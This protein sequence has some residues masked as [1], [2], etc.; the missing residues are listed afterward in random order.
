MPKPHS[1]AGIAFIQTQQ[2]HA[3]MADTVLE[4]MCLLDINSSPS[5]PAT[6]A[7]FVPLGLLP[8]LWRC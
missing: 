4:H 2:L 5:Q 7:S 1:E 6:L 8:D 3:A